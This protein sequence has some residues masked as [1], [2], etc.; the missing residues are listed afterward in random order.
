MSDTNQTPKRRRGPSRAFTPPTPRNSNS[1]VASAATPKRAW[2]SSEQEQKLLNFLCK[3]CN[4][5]PKRMQ[6]IFDEFKEEYQLT[7]CSKTIQL[8]FRRDLAPK[9]HQLEGLD[10]ESK[11]RLLYATGTPVDP[12]FLKKLQKSA[13]VELDAYQRI[14]KFES[15]S[16]K[17]SGKLKTNAGIPRS[18]KRKSGRVAIARP[19]PAAPAAAPASDVD[20]EM[21]GDRTIRCAPMR[22][23]KNEPLDEPAGGQ[24]MVPHVST[25]TSNYAPSPIHPAVHPGF[26]MAGMGNFFNSLTGMIQSQTQLITEMARGAS[27][28]TPL[29]ASADH[30]VLEFLKHI[31]QWLLNSNR[32][33]LGDI[34]AKI[35]MSLHS[36]AGRAKKIPASR[37]KMALESAFS[38]CSSS[39]GTG[40]Q[41]MNLK[42][43]ATMLLMYAS[44]QQMYGF[45]A[46]FKQKIDKIDAQAVVPIDKIRV[47]LEVALGMVLE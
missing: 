38:I 23:V 3:K 6:D 16:L 4:G 40:A 34:H 21:L 24:E 14:V 41:C 39:I 31:Q 46:E 43:F 37:V 2:K 7:P 9:I 8:H 1:N 22:I 47:A 17:L 36:L 26:L 15:P 33:Q 44:S 10:D 5:T 32:I 30:S 13:I 25:P 20:V 29:V 12:A 27:T 35:V 18:V 11:A 19:P 28:S 45:C 42:E